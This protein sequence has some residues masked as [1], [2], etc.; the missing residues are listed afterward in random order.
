MLCLMSPEGRVPTTHPLRRIKTL[1]DKA[2][3]E[4]SPVFGQ[5]YADSGRPSIPP[6]R[7]LK[8]LL[9][10][11]LYSVR[12]ERLLCEQLDY[13]LLFRWFLDMDMIEPSFDAS[14]FSK[15]RQRLMAHDVA[16]AFFAAVVTEAKRNNLMS[17]EHFSVDGTLIDAWA[18]LKS[19][20]KKDGSDD[21]ES[22][23]SPSNRWVPLSRKKAIQRNARVQDRPRGE[24]DAQRPWQGVHA[25][26]FCPRPDGEPKRPAG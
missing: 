3:K 12:S 10:M 17:S 15:N 7:L 14:T 11:A 2:L 21:E 16:G 6:E 22:K 13:N 4:L 24:A 20:R 8:S 9:L 23:G 18:S 26:V 25:V 5:M 1:A 19:F